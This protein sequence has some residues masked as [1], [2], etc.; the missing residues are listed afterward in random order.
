MHKPESD[1][2]S[3]EEAA[4]AGWSSTP[5]A[6][7]RV[8]SVDVV[9]DRAE[10]VIATDDDQ[11]HGDWVYCVRRDGLWREVVSGNG[12]SSGLVRSKHPA[13][14]LT[15]LAASKT[16]RQHCRSALT[17]HRRSGQSV[18]PIFLRRLSRPRRARHG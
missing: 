8:V 14:G 9:G 5:S 15:K 10:V 16:A 6:R 18:L 7:A 11:D 17:E 3:P 13:L 2:D 12:P 4:L 1:Y